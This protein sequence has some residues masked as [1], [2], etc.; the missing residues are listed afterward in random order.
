M[1]RN[2]SSQSVGDYEKM[3]KSV[4]GNKAQERSIQSFY[5][6]F[7]A[8]YAVKESRDSLRARLIKPYLNGS[9]IN[10]LDAGC[11]RGLLT[12]LMSNF[13]A[14]NLIVGTDISKEA[15]KIAHQAIPRKNVEFVAAD[16]AHLPFKQSSFGFVVFSE[17]I[18]HVPYEER[19][20]VLHEL[21]NAI[22]SRGYLFF[23]M[24]NPIHIVILLRKILN[25]ISRTRIAISDQIFDDP[26]TL[27]SLI[28]LFND[29]AFTLKFLTFFDYTTGTRVKLRLPKLSVSAIQVIAI[30]SPSSEKKS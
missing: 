15:C 25:R 18:E 17:V 1:E 22:A 21:R 24:P 4:L 2:R 7:W 3:E 14:K 13:C 11:G 8:G 20:K 26:P 16:L 6:S 19:M 30:V 12:Y 10:I 9:G 5:D 23:T 29:S 27:R 28:K